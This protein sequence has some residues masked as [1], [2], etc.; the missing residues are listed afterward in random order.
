MSERR[1]VLALLILSSAGL[2][3]GA[4]AQATAEFRRRVED[5]QRTARRV[6]ETLQAAAEVRTRG[7]VLDTLRRGPLN[8][9]IAPSLEP[10]A[11]A[12][13]DSTWPAIERTY[14][15]AIADLGNTAFVLQALDAPEGPVPPQPRSI[16]ILASASARPGDVAISLRQAL[17]T[18]IQQ[19]M[20][21]GLAHWVGGELL[22]MLPDSGFYG[23]LYLELT[24]SPWHRV[25]DCRR[26]DL[27][28][29][30]LAL[31]VD[32]RDDPTD[33]WYDAS[34]RRR[35]V[36]TWLP[37]ELSDVT[38][39]CLRGQDAACR[40][41]LVGHGTGLI[42]MPLGGAARLALLD[43]VLQHG[44]TGAYDRLLATR[45]QP[46]DERLAAAAAIPADS[47]FAAWRTRVLSA[48]PLPVAVSPG[49]AWVAVGWCLL[50]AVLSMRSSRWR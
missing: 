5:L 3:G 26:G 6:H 9:V 15:R 36:A 44:G 33:R 17:A 48:Q 4:H 49:S 11:T 18:Q 14:G 37:T 22:P 35:M 42:S 32:G 25:Q 21:S 27:P 45:G 1:S 31:G 28:S 43:I 13:L 34:D 47:V 8:L 24:I 12:A 10:V 29:C 23:P 40:Q 41:V 38:A 39:L 19:G 7:M 46:I 30:R 20:D 2:A 50:L 16:E